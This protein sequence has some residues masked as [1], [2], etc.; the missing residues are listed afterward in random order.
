MKYFKIINL[1]IFIL[2][3]FFIIKFYFSKNFLLLKNKNRENFSTY[4]DK[5]IKKIKVINTKKDF[6]EFQDN[7][8]YLKKNIEEKQFWQLLKTK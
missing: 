1:I 6:K 8:K 5:E 7:S 3:F 2:F 4:L